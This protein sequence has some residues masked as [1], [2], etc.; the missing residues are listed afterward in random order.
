MPKVT[1]DKVN[2]EKIKVKIIPASEPNIG[3][4]TTNI[5]ETS[6]VEASKEARLDIGKLESFT[7]VAQT[8]DQI[9][10]TIDTMMN[11][12]T[13][14]A[15]LE[16]YTADAIDTNDDGQIVWCEAS[17]SNVS[18]YVTYLLE[19]LNI[20]KNIPR[21]TK[22]F[23]KYGDLYVKL[24]RQSDIETDELFGDKNRDLK[25]QVNLSVHKDT[26]HFVHYVEAVSN[27]SEFFELTRY[28]KTVGFIEAPI[29]VQTPFG[30]LQEASGMNYLRYKLRKKDI[31]VYGPLDYVH[32]S[33]G[34]NSSRVQEEVNIYM[35]NDTSADSNDKP[36]V[37]QVKRGESLFNNIFR[38]WREM[39]L[40][41]NSVM[42][43]RI[44]KSANIRILSVE[45]GDMPKEQAQN[46][47]SR[48]KSQIEQKSALD[49]G[50]SMADYTNPGPIDN[51]IYVPTHGGIGNITSSTIGGDVD[52]KTLVDL[53]WFNNRLFGSL[54]VPKQYFGWTDD[55]AGFSG[56]KSLS[57]ISSRYGKKVKYIQTALCQMITDIINIL[58]LDA[59]YDSYINQFTIKM[60]API[61]QE[62][63]DRREANDNR[64]RYV[65]DVMNQLNDV[66]D[67]ARRL[68]ITK[69]LLSNV[70]S[71][72]EV[73]SLL[74]EEIDAIEEK[75][76][77]ASDEEN[78]ETPEDS[79]L[80]LGFSGGLDTPEL[81]ALDSVPD[82]INDMPELSVDDS[83][84]DID[85]E[86]P[87]DDTDTLPTPDD[88]GIDMT[89]NF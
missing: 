24:F 18:N 17:D 84:E 54:G 31:N 39:T 89:Q 41:E 23:I 15:I 35:N 62:E 76:A 7:T 38:V 28:G 9:Y 46:L 5:L 71:S 29:Q 61:T 40:L 64:I 49:E 27:P 75:E 34:D 68:K 45:V 51:V 30:N 85:A 73:T 55:G 37:Y 80:D 83:I 59:G 86:M 74:Q 88:L 42:L 20:D 56:G 19:S 78:D 21:W 60:Q 10:S 26:D 22:K 14:S 87:A 12:S 33:L 69:A 79:D 44:T 70:L 2:N 47:L 66:E 48:I 50:E 36:L 63:L 3:I 77:A 13:L 43:A 16:C 6:I 72:N 67:K 52:P 58:L 82:S 8:R 81:D 65:G 57:I 1:N 53:D 25:E 11:D 32:A 4:D